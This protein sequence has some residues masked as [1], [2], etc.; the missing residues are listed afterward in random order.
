MHWSWRQKGHCEM[1][2]NLIST[3]FTPI[4][5]FFFWR[6]YD[7]HIGILSWCGAYAA[8][9]TTTTEF[10]AVNGESPFTTIC[11]FTPWR[12]CAEISWNTCFFSIKLL[13]NKWKVSKTFQNKSFIVI[14][15]NWLESEEYILTCYTSLT[16][17]STV[18]SLA[19][20]F[21]NGL[22]VLNSFKG[23]LA[24]KGFWTCTADT[25]LGVMRTDTGFYGFLIYFWFPPHRLWM[26]CHLNS[27]WEIFDVR[28]CL[29]IWLLISGIPNGCRAKAILFQTSSIQPKGT[30]Y[31]AIG[32]KKLN[33][34][35]SRMM[36]NFC[37]LISK[38]IYEDFPSV[39]NR[40]GSI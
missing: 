9:L 4:A 33:G 36:I 40:F 22:T 26:F 12:T 39:A 21:W 25:E 11:G 1:S 10:I 6:G 24:T 23:D 18:M 37:L 7:R 16:L 30:K 8:R 19:A 20:V 27:L 32:Q 3:S 31:P 29:W 15:P 38:E 35:A 2:F 13:P 14:T 28:W 34:A 5:T 17:P